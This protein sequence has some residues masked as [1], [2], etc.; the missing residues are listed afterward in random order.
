MV[1]VKFAWRGRSPK[2]VACGSACSELEREGKAM[3]RSLE[4]GVVATGMVVGG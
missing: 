3:R 2:L 4:T 1:A